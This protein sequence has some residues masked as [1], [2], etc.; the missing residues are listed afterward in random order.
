M[1]IV[2]LRIPYSA[3]YGYDEITGTVTYSGGVKVGHAVEYSTTINRSDDNHLYG[4]DMIAETAKGKF[5][6]GELTLITTEF[7]QEISKTLLGLKTISKTIGG[8]EVEVTV[9]DDDAVSPDLGFGIIEWHQINN[10]DQFRAVVLLRAYFNIPDD[11]ATTQGESV[12]WQT[13]EITGAIMRSEINNSEEKHPWK[14][15][16]WFATADEADAFLQS[17]LNITPAVPEA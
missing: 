15:E 10:A 11:A 3:K 4:D 14:Y 13:P 7:T 8:S 2:G 6:N 16:A 5:Q 1:A 12:E 17:I 9:Y